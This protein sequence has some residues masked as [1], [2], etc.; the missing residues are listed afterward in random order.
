[1]LH[2]VYLYG[3]FGV[4][5]LKLVTILIS[6]NS[7]NKK[8]YIFWKERKTERLKREKTEYQM[9]WIKERMNGRMKERKKKRKKKSKKE[10]RRDTETESE[11][12]YSVYFLVY[13]FNQALVQ[14][15]Q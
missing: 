11:G 15:K 9:Q 8:I 14:W 12:E 13:G 5:S 4:I 1:M 10:R 2:M 7:I 6:I 3:C